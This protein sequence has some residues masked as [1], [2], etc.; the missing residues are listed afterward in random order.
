[1]A[2]VVVEV[3]VKEGSDVKAGDPLATMSAMKVRLALP[4]S[5][6]LPPSVTVADPTPRLCHSQMETNVSAPVSGKV[7]RIAVA[8][9][10]SLSQGDLVV[11]IVHA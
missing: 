4:A 5:L 9:G 8:A 11:E 1:M 2:G 7:K 6:P 3:L 10:D